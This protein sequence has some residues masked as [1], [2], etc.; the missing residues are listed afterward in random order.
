MCDLFK[1]WYLSAVEFDAYFQCLQRIVFKDRLFLTQLCGC[2]AGELL[3]YLMND[4]LPNFAFEDLG[5]R[6]TAK[7][8]CF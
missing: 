6:R 3:P 7:G 5:V 4:F 8:S 2:G 1:H